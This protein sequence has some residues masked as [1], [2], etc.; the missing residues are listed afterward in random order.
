MRAVTVG[1]GPNQISGTALWTL[2]AMANK[3]RGHR[4]DL[5]N[6]FV[7]WSES[8]KPKASRRAICRRTLS[9]KLPCGVAWV[10]EDT[11]IPGGTGVAVKPGASPVL[12]SSAS[13]TMRPC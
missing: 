3:T 10:R 9:G 2:D 5:S 7:Y 1:T 4:L 13:P 12:R 8:G 6:K 11:I